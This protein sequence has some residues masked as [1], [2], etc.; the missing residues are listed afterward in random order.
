MAEWVIFSLA[1][2]GFWGI[3]GLLQKLSTNWISAD[4]VF[5]WSRV[6]YLPVLAWL[7][8]TTSLHNLSLEDVGL[9]ILVGLTNGLGAWYLYASLENGAQA[10]VAVPLTSLYPLLTVL[11]AVGFLREHP[12]PLQWVGIGVAI[13]AGVLMSF[14]SPSEAAANDSSGRLVQD[15]RKAEL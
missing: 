1:T 14:E 12:K 6:G 9:G 11:L 7:L 15:E 4:S 10:S 5:I 3:M 2:I 13:V 8:V